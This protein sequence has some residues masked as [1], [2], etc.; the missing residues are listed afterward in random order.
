MILECKLISTGDIGIQK[1]L[2][3]EIMDVKADE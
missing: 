3:D 1:H 2:V